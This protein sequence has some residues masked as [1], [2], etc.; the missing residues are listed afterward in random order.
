MDNQEFTYL[1]EHPDHID[2]GNTRD[3]KTVLEHH[4]YFQAAHSLYLKG[5]KNSESPHYNQ[6]LKNTAA[7]TQDRSVLFDFITSAIFH[8]HA[9]GQRIKQR[10]DALYKVEVHDAQNVTEQMEHEELDKAN[11]VLDPEFFI[12]REK[13]TADDSGDK[14]RLQQGKP[15]EFTKEETHSFTEWLKITSFEPIERSENASTEIEEEDPDR[16]RK[17]KLID[18]FITNN[19][20]IK[21]KPIDEIKKVFVEDKNIPSENLMTET[22]A[23]VYIEQKNYKKAKQAFKILS[24]K[25]PEKSG[26][27]ADQI[28]AVELLQENKSK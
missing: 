11:A 7:R 13:K 23:R 22:L 26:F 1:L 9:I 14:D 10:E 16:R 20:K 17:I 24:L 2:N 4:P 19:P 3:L 27:F 21:V 18:R 12:P 15:L 5:L 8:Q 6:A 28:R 25:Y